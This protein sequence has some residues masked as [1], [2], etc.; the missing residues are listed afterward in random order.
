VKFDGVMVV[1]VKSREV[2][3]SLSRVALKP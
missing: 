1:N 2:M 3:T